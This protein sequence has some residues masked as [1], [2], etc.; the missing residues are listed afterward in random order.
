MKEAFSVIGP[1]IVIE[2]GLFG[3]RV[4]T[5]AAASP[6]AEAVTASRRGTDR[7]SCSAVFPSTSGT[8]CATSSMSH[9]QEILRVEIRCV[10][11]VGGRRDSVRDS[12]A[13]SPTS[14]HVTNACG[15]VLR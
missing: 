6:T 2:A 7:D 3:A 5:G 8:H 9:R 10:S 15:T 11:L 4:R 12:S 14:P 13:T 1:F